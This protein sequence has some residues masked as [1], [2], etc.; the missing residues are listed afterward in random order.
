[1]SK[2]KTSINSD[3][4]KE[5]SLSELRHTIFRKVI[6]MW[7]YNIARINVFKIF[8]N[9]VNSLS[10]VS[11]N[12]SLYIFCNKCFGLFSINKLC[13]MSEQTSTSTV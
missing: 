12:K 8:N 3:T 9:S 10:T 5:N 11:S 7:F 13:K 1:M 2:I 6:Q 4:D